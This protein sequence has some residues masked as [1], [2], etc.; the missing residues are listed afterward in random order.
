MTPTTYTLTLTIETDADPCNL[1]EL[2]QAAIPQLQSDLESYGYS[3]WR[4]G[5]AEDTT[6]H[7]TTSY[8]LTKE[9]TT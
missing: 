7:E 1:L 2:L 8:T 4:P 3:L 6:Q 5:D 9:P